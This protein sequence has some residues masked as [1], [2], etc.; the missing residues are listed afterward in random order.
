MDSDLPEGTGA[1]CQTCICGKS[2]SRPE[3]YTHHT[4]NCTK[5]KKRL[6]DALVKAKEVWRARKRSRLAVCASEQE[7]AAFSQDVVLAPFRIHVPERPG[8]AATVRVF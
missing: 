7:S 8:G 6:A 4:R 2:F 3:T 1:F 5:T